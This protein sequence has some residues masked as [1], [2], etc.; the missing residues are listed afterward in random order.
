MLPIREALNR[1][2]EEGLDLVEVAPS[3]KPPVCKIVDF[4]KLRFEKRRQLQKA[5][6][7]SKRSELKEFRFG[8]TIGQ[9]DLDIRIQRAREFL[10]NNDKVKITIQFKGREMAHPELGFDKIKQVTSELADVARVESEP[11]R[12]GYFLSIVLLPK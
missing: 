2:R 4:K 12:K 5:K 1:A 8:P 7:K 11:I 6:R 3:A 9:H 10:E